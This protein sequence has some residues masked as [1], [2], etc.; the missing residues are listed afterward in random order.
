MT[1]QTKSTVEAVTYEV[2]T[3]VDP[4]TGDTILPIPPELLQRMGW[5]EGDEIDFGKDTEG[6]IILTKR[7]GS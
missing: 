2:V 7:G 1:E 6:R 5:K 4:E 3:Q